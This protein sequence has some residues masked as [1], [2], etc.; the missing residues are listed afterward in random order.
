MVKRLSISMLCGLF[1]AT[2]LCTGPVQARQNDQSTPDNT[3]VN[4]R[5]RNQSEVTA[6]QAKNNTSDREIAAHIRRDVVK[7]KTLSTY[8]HNV[9]V[10]ADHGKV[11]LKGPVRSDEEKRAIEEYARKYASDGNIN[12]EMTVKSK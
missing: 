8:G 3:K 5:D 12:D 7:D 9:K 11:T 2:L 1:M 4:Q 10:I 6:D